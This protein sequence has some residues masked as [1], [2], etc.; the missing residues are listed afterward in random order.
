[1]HSTGN[2]PPL[3]LMIGYTDGLQIWSIPVS[4]SFCCT[5]HLVK[6]DIGVFCHFKI[7]NHKKLDADLYFLAFRIN[8]LPSYYNM[9]Q[10]A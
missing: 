5:V 4:I 6:S 3:L 10:V 9:G 7:Y 8:H 1:M 2:D